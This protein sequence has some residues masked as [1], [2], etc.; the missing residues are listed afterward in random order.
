MAADTM[1][2]LSG[3]LREQRRSLLLWSLALAA[4]AALYIAVYPAIGGDGQMQEMVDNL[5]EAMVNAFGYDQ[6]GDPGGYLGST[7]YGLLG[8]VL[9]LTFA[10]GAGARLI[11]GQEEDGSLEL[12]FAAPVSRRQVY[13]ERLGALWLDVTLLVAVVMV[14]TFLLVGPLDMDVAALHILAGSAGLL[15]LVLG[16]GTVALAVGAVT[17]RKTMALA[18]AAGLAVLAYMLN[19]IGPT[20]EAGWMTAISPSGAW[21]CWRP[22]RSWPLWPACS[23]SSAAT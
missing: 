5:P 4:V 19:A 13:L 6:I 16:M 23:P 15:L 17:G 14:M 9:L 10:I 22:S 18:A 1:P 11:A 21:C 20:L 3:V 2:V 8:P 7:V 12:E